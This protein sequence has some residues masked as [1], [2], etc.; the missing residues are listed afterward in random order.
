MAERSSEVALPPC[1]TPAWLPYEVEGRIIWDLNLVVASIILGAAF[2]ALALAI[3]LRDGS[4]KSKITGALVLTVAICSHHFTAMGA[5]SIIPDPTVAVSESALPTSWLAIAV[6][7]ASFAVIILAFAG[8]ALDVRERRHAER[9]ADRMRG[10]ANAAVEGLL[11][12]D[13]EIIVTANKSFASLAG[14]DAETMV[15]QE[16]RRVLS[17]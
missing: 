5:V 4:M 2:G 6:A 10:L 12:C 14:S 8:V 16:A 15:E 7:L 17:G 13:G 11:V 1:I 3:G 9:E